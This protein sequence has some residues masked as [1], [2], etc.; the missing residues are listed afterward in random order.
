VATPKPRP[1]WRQRHDGGWEI[2]GIDDRAISEFSRRRNEIDEVKAAIAERLGRPLSPEEGHHV[3]M[4]TRDPKQ[5][6]DPNAL[7][8]E[9]QQRAAAVGL[10]VEDCFDRDTDRATLPTRLVAR[11][12]ADLAHPTRGVCALTSTF[13]RG[14]V[15][16]AIA[17][18]A[19]DDGGNRHK[20]LLPPAEIERLTDD[21]LA[22]P[23]VVQLDT[24]ASFRR[25]DGGSLTDGQGE[26]NFTTAELL[27]VQEE[28]HSRYQAG[29]GA[30]GAVAAPEH[31]R[32]LD[33]EV[34]G[35][36][37]SAE[38]RRLVTA[39]CTSGHRV[40]AAVGR[41]GTGKTTAMRAAATAWRTAGFRVIGSA[42]KAEATRQLAADAHIE[43]ETVALLLA[44]AAAGQ[45]V[46]DPRTVLIVDEASTLGDRDLL[47]VLRLAD[48]TGATVRLIGDTA[49]HGS[50]P[51]GGSYTAI[52]TQH[53]ADTP[54]LTDVKRLR[55]PGER[56]R[57]DLVR[58]RHVA[59]ALEDLQASGQL[60][61]TDSDAD[62]Y[63]AM[64]QRWYQS[65]RTAELIPWCTGAIANAASSTSSPNNF[66]PPTA[67]STSPPR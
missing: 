28:I 9:W 4:T 21:F 64:L 47:A 59:A 25:R 16:T 20:V 46:L 44:R 45:T 32:H 2:A 41:A 18:W 27:A 56:R 51:A 26:P 37:L 54:E 33:A 39:W 7:Q 3:A 24:D 31:L 62:T 63:A 8:A 19:I 53:P 57:A 40:Q 38:Q 22:T 23:H 67:R 58:R 13:D 29:Q 5:A 11:L 10:R 42:V 17:D 43:A 12:H 66:S 50:V 61:L 15:I 14:D 52:V 1:G 49:Q 48:H 6:V 34:D 36:T 35:F 65:R 30:G 55:D 60:V